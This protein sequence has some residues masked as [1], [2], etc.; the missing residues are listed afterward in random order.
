MK[1]KKKLTDV[2]FEIG[3]C[4]SVSQAKLLI[5]L[6]SVTGDGGKRV[7]DPETEVSSGDTF[8]AP[9]GMSKIVFEVP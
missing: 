8:S 3:C 2:M 5:C 7:V 9:V 1:D 4:T 6:G